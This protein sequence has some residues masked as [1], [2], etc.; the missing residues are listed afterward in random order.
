MPLPFLNAPE[1]SIDMITQFGG[2]NHRTS[3]ADNQFFDMKNMSSKDFPLISTRNKRGRFAHDSLLNAQAIAAKDNIVFA[4]TGYGDIGVSLAQ[5]VVAR[6]LETPPVDPE[7][8]ALKKSY[9][10]VA[11]CISNDLTEAIL[12]KDGVAGFGTYKYS[13]GTFSTY[14]G[15]ALVTDLKDEDGRK[16]VR[17]E[18]PHGKIGK[19][20]LW[21]K[22]LFS[23]GSH[24]YTADKAKISAKSNGMLAD[25]TNRKLLIG[26]KVFINSFGECTI[27]SIKPSQDWTLYFYDDWIVEFDKDL[28]NSCEG[29][30]VFV[31]LTEPL[32]A[33]IP[34]VSEVVGEG[35][36]N[37]EVLI[38]QPSEI[39]VSAATDNHVK[40]LKGKSVDFTDANGTHTC[41]VSDVKIDGDNKYIYIDV[42]HDSI[43]D[44]ATAYG[45]RLFLCEYNPFTGEAV[46][47]DIFSAS[48]AP[49]TILEMGANVV[50][51][52][53]KVVV[54]TQKR[55]K[56]NKQFE[57]IQQLELIET[58]SGCYISLTDATND[59]YKADEVEV[60]NTAPLNPQN[61]HGWIDISK[62]PP[63][64]CVY[65]E[66]I[67]QWAQTNTY[68]RISNENMSKDWQVGDA[69]ELEFDE[70]G[71]VGDVISPIAG[72]KYFVISEV[73]EGFVKFPVAMKSAFKKTEHLVSIKRTVP[74]M[75][76]IIE[77]ENRLWGCKYGEVDGEAINEIFA[78]KLGD[79]K[80]WH[81]FTN[82]S[83]D[84]YYVSLGADGEFTGAISYAGSPHF[85][86]EGCVHRIYGNY[87]SNY[88]LKTINCHGVEKGSEKGITIMND[89]MYYKSPVG[90]MAYT[91]AAPIAVSECFG[92]ERYKN[93]VAGAVGSK[94]YFSMQD[95]NGNN[96]LFTFD[97]R[98]K[99][100]HKEDNLRCKEMVVYENDVYALTEHNE[101][102]AM[103]GGVGVPED[104][105]IKLEDDFE[106]SVTSGNIGYNTPFFKQITRLNIRMHLERNSRAS[107]SIQYDSDGN[108]Y[109][110]AN[111]QSTGKMR[112]ISLPISPQRCDHFALKI[113]G[114]GAAKI[115]SITKFT[116]G[117]SENE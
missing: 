93:A 69:V 75:D 59:G 45:D 101:L 116:E 74:D 41:K 90:I 5:D 60:S 47:S 36:N 99:L 88:A 3:I 38:N 67:E 32:G 10:D 91:G 104:G 108:W 76:F 21:A 78:C 24:W 85:F 31:M 51:F 117:G 19:N 9:T 114:K 12:G 57:D 100:W 71:I 23:L 94:M 107:V 11:E 110:V 56:I 109:H 106:W 40:V 81:H 55:N 6:E 105:I 35:D 73:G 111:I 46:T 48:N 95:M 49:H 39:K 43:G 42:P 61:G 2:Y 13:N 113:E 1:Q 79:P 65:S 8:D 15:E 22:Q 115:L 96:V 63:R 28:E 37:N 87:P 62:S 68:C 44:G 72:Q 17:V 18:Q 66:Q 50:I 80:N 102:L 54:N 103:E 89:V 25:E 83:L 92:N 52:P 70:A 58:L 84:S 53:E 16:T 20:T 33:D 98:T 14:T 30:T 7:G 97:D 27:K 34:A 64:F 82:T 26:K 4:F 112:N 77:N 86:R 29:K